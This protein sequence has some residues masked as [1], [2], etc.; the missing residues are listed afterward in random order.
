M[1]VHQYYGNGAFAPDSRSLAVNGVTINP[2]AAIPAGPAVDASALGSG[3][4]QAA[5]EALI[6]QV[7]QRTGMNVQFASMCLAQNG[8]VFE[9]ALKNFE[10][11]KASIPAEAYQ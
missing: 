10:E 2:I 3:P 7:R 5:Q 6:N 4:D 8:W 11:I 1:I 9:T